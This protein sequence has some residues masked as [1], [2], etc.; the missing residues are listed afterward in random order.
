M[1]I[2][3]ENPPVCNGNRGPRCFR[4]KRFVHLVADSRQE[5]IKY[6]VSIGMKIEWLQV[7]IMGTPHFDVVGEKLN[8]VQKD[9]A[10]TKLSWREAISKWHE[11][12]KRE[13]EMAL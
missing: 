12:A 2:Y 5:L 6:A 7:S 13:K 8:I 10:V 11:I 9:P 4:N 1:A 3:I